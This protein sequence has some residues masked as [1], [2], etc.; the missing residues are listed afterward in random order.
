MTRLTDKER[1]KYIDNLNHIAGVLMSFAH[2]IRQAEKVIRVGP[3][4]IAAGLL[5]HPVS[6]ER[7]KSKMMLSRDSSGPEESAFFSRCEHKLP[8]Y[9]VSVQQVRC[10]KSGEVFVG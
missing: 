10:P 6:S 3:G 4:E 2:E 7:S 1:I 5:V 8:M 9:R